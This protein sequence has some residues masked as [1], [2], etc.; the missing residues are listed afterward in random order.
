MDAQLGNYTISADNKGILSLLTAI[1]QSEDH[2]N[3]ESSPHK[4]GDKEPMSVST[5]NFSNLNLETLSSEINLA[6]LNLCLICGRNFNVETANNGMIDINNLIDIPGEDSRSI[7]SVVEEIIPI[8]RSD[9]TDCAEPDPDSGYVCVDCFLLVDGILKLR[10]Q[11]HEYISTLR[12][13][14]L[15]WMSKKKCSKLPEL[16]EFR[17]PISILS[18]R[19]E[20]ASATLSE[21]AR[22]AS[23]LS[24]EDGSTQSSSTLGGRVSTGYKKSKLQILAETLEDKPRSPSSVVET[25]DFQLPSEGLEDTSNDISPDTG[26]MVIRRTAKHSVLPVTNSIDPSRL[27]HLDKVNID[28]ENLEMCLSCGQKLKPSK[29]KNNKPKT[30]CDKCVRLK[31]VEKGFPCIVCGLLL[32]SRNLLE[33]HKKTKHSSPDQIQFECSKCVQVFSSKQSRTK[34]ENAVHKA[35]QSMEC[36]E[37][38]ESFQSVQTLQFHKSRHTGEFS[39]KCDH[40][41]KGFNNFKLLEEHQHIHTGRKPYS[42]SQCPKSFANRGSL[43]LHVKK[44]QNDKPYIC[45][46]CSKGFGHAS[47]LAVHK[48]MHTGERPY[49]CR[50]CEEGFV[51]SNHLKRHMKSHKNEDPFA[52]GLCNQTFQKRSALSQHGLLEHG[53]KVVDAALVAM[54]NNTHSHHK[55]NV[56]SLHLTKFEGTVFEHMTDTDSSMAAT[57][58]S[59]T[60]SISV[61][62]ALTTPHQL[63]AGSSGSSTPSVAT[64]KISTAMTSSAAVGRSKEYLLVDQTDQILSLPKLED[65]QDFTLPVNIM[66]EDV[67]DQSTVFIQVSENPPFQSGFMH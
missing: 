58:S 65:N 63:T 14:Y 48:R 12:T 17:I 55:Q 26:D 31:G 28:K 13:K 16:L 62:E 9:Q 25:E 20:E 3:P 45:D 39:Y 38:G 27:H 10:A 15:D 23:E 21:L 66:E 60:A 1:E 41:G 8:M 43:W 51:S 59:L 50:L 29:L 40:C 47:H 67:K 52:C 19:D 54:H 36:D 57:D 24:R 42:C 7:Q 30:Y 64:D 22:D 37:C 11:I 53:G 44:H 61:S 2:D 18:V 46:F 6:N 49:S 32:K 56:D 5:D 34:H 33:A 35:R 4:L